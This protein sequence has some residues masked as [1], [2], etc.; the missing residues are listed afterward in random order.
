MAGIAG[1]PAGVVYRGNLREGSRFG[2]VC[3][4]TA[5]AKHGGVQFCWLERSGVFRMLGERPMTGLARHSLVFTLCFRFQN[6][7]MAALASLVAAKGNRATCDFGDGISAVVSVLSEGARNQHAAQ[8]EED[9]EP[10]Q[11]DCCQPEEVTCIF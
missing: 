1:E 8:H 9:D 5:G 7:G 10:H 4:V 2:D 6:V 3:L 11:K